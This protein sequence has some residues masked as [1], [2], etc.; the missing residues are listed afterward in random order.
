MTDR[1]RINDSRHYTGSQ[2]KS[3]FNS[4]YVG[5]EI[6]S[7]SIEAWKFIKISLK[8]ANSFIYVLIKE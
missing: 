2:N 8:F 3:Q 6:S 4:N 1:R 7:I 5:L